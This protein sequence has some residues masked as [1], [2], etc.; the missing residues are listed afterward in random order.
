[1]SETLN[2]ILV[3]LEAQGQVFGVTGIAQPTLV[4]LFVL[5]A[6]NNQH[7]FTVKADGSVDVDPKYTVGQAADEFWKWM[8]TSTNLIQLAVDQAKRDEREAV[9]KLVENQGK[10]WGLLRSVKM[11]TY[12]KAAQDLANLI[13]K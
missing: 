2:S 10:Q 13:R 12:S 5:Y 7:V 9:A 3:A 6:N 8:N 1:M 4:N 11:T